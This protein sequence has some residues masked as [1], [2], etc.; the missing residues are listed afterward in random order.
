[1][2]RDRGWNACLFLAIRCGQRATSWKSRISAF[3]GYALETPRKKLQR[4]IERKGKI[5][6]DGKEGEE[7]RATVVASRAASAKRCRGGSRGIVENCSS[8][9]WWGCMGLVGGGGSIEWEDWARRPRSTFQWSGG[10]M[11]VP[12]SLDQGLFLRCR[13]GG[14]QRIGVGRPTT[15]P[16][17]CPE[18]ARML[19]RARLIT[20][21]GVPQ[22]F[23]AANFSAGRR[24]TPNSF[25][26]GARLLVRS[27]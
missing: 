21:R 1:M 2:L 25:L 20:S 5:S 17:A 13:T 19:Y 23:T 6:Y 27:V 3:D 8:I 16:G 9:R 12:L 15:P 4:E 22:W 7:E 11:F 14:S 10:A 26:R 18:S 24:T